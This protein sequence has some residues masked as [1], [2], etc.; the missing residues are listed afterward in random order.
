MN[1]LSRPSFA[2]PQLRDTATVSTI[3]RDVIVA[4]L[5]A[6]GMSVFLFGVRVLALTAISVASCVISEKLYCRFTHKPDPTRDLSAC[7]TGVLLAM[8]LPV[9]T[10][11]WA[12]V[13]GGAFA[14]VI[15]KQFYG[16]L[17]RNFMNPALAARMLLLSFPGMMTTLTQALDR[18]PLWGAAD[19]VSAATPM[20]YLHTGALPPQTLSQMLLGQHGGALGEGAAFMLILGG[21]YLLGRQVISWRIPV[22]FL[23]TVALLTLLFPR[24]ECAPAVWMLYNLMGGGLLLGAIFMACDYTTSPVTPRGQLMFGVGC[25]C[26]TVVLRYFGSYPDGVGFAI[27]T[28]NCCVWLLDRV[29][30]P[31]RFGVRPLTQLRLW[32]R[33]QR[34]RLAS[35]K[36]AR[37]SLPAWEP[38]TMPG[39]HYLEQLRPWLRQALAL[40]GVIAVTAAVV[41]SV[42]RLTQLPA[43]ERENSAQQALLSQVMPQADMVTQ[44][45]YWAEGA[46]SITAGYRDNQLLGYCVEVEV[47]GFGGPITMVVGVDLNGEVTGIA[48][49]A[50][51]EQKV[52]QPAL[53]QDYL[54]RYVGLSGTVRLEGPNS[55]DGISGATDT[56]RAITAG[57]NEALYIVSR[58]DTDDVTYTDGEV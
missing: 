23:G 52:G 29:G 25:G 26:L 27:L 10:P 32:L 37:P 33:R 44:T 58:L 47:Q 6:L 21:L 20:S 18:Q 46:R 49:T 40:G 1:P 53:E 11:Y 55:V 9:T 24:G 50:H 3:M 4:L 35:L 13:L 54:Q 39:E 14:I 56:C 8:S 5:P 19:A 48:V 34:S 57:V 12:P 31:R 7:V 28:M 16:G 17:G 43:A 30:L 15:I 38:G 41:F 51:S 45:P 22:S 42:H 2:P 36:P